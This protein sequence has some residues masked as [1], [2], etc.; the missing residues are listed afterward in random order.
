[1]TE[2]QG[3]AIV[4]AVLGT[5]WVAEYRFAPPRKWRFDFANPQRQI[6]IEIE[7][8]VYTRGRHTRPTGFLRDIEKYN[9]ATLQGWRVLRCTPQTFAELLPRVRDLQIEEDRRV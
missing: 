9:T 8:G 7:G 5:D 1:M 4:R 6:A 3:L 2:S